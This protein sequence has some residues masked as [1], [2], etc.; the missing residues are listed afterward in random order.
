[1]YKNE[2][3]IFDRFP[4]DFAAEL[5]AAGPA[6]SNL[7]HCCDAGAQGLGVLTQNKL[8]PAAKLELRLG[9]PNGQAPFRGLASVIWSQKD[10]QGQ[11][12]SG[13]QFEHVDFMGIRRLFATLN[14]SR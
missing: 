8:T 1:M 10:K 11:W 3:R 4:V 2:R 7:A 12:R 9:L 14:K 5:K 6:R 13:L